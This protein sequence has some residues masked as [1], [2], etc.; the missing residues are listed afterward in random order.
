M[1][2]GMEE[3]CEVT[4]GS[5]CTGI[6]GFDL[7]LELAGHNPIWMCEQN[8]SCRDVLRKHWP[9]IPCYEDMLSDE[10]ESLERPDILCGG[11]PCQGFSVAGL[12]KSLADD[13]SNLCL[14]FVRLCDILNPGLVLWE[15]VPGCL[16]TPDNAFG[17]FLAALVGADAPLVPPENIR[18]WND[19]KNGRYFAWT[20]A[21]LVAGPRRTAAWRTLDSQYLGVAQ[22][23]E[24]VF[25][26][27]DTGD[28]RAAQI[29]FESESVR[30]SI[31]PRRETRQ[32]TAHSLAPC[33]GASGRGFER[34]GDTRGQ[35]A[36][37]PINMQA[38][39]KCG[40]KSPN[41][42]GIGQPGDPA[43]TV[44]ASDQHA[45]AIPNGV[46]IGFD[47]KQGGDTQLGAT[48]NL[49]PPL[50]GQDRHAVAHSLRA[51]GFDASEDGTGRGIPLV[52]GTLNHNGKAAGSATQQD[53]ESGMLLVFD[54][55]Q[56]TSKT[57]R[58]NPQP[59]DACHPL[60]EGAHAPAIAFERRMVRTTGGQPSE[61]LQPTLRAD[62]N[63][64]DGSPC[65][66]RG[67]AVRRLT[68]TECCRL[69]GF[70]DHWN[71]FAVNDKGVIY[72][73][74]DGPRYKQLG[75]AVTVNVSRWIGG[76][77]KSSATGSIIPS[78]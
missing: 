10:I 13:R 6:G 12:R 22:R 62:E 76:R 29:L 78:C 69:Q 73:Q 21:G 7:G 14:R 51:D 71:K 44:N 70:P 41:M 24:R 23:R 77:I 2:G 18:R 19:G 26:V 38:A 28:G 45:V 67:M 60:A 3:R 48:E 74:A 65:V 34:T 31:P 5:L 59:G 37:I 39:A 20:S 40:A 15:N 57:N 30:R 53:A 35:D 64:G 33:I 61:E 49:C 16:S 63:S 50:K 58:S 11:T 4:F 46:C 68:P 66:A 42:L 43:M 17:C 75:N 36:V 8:K 27:C 56:V 1:R 25:V 32:G 9:K 72:E 55:T 52:V 47:S 54:T